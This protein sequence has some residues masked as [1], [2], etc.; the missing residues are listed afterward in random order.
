MSLLAPD[1]REIQGRDPAPAMDPNLSL[2][3]SA[4][5]AL[6]VL[7]VMLRARIHRSDVAHAWLAS[8]ARK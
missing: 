4:L 6:A 3:A 8:Q 1:V 7:Y 5:G 2:A